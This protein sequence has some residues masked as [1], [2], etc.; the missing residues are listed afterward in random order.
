M[1]TP[2]DGADRTLAGREVDSVHAHYTVI[3]GYMWLS[4][5]IYAWISFSCT[6]V[7]WSDV[8]WV[9]RSV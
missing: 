8:F 7:K 2:R 5:S 9:Q 6:A 3:D 4:D 1:G